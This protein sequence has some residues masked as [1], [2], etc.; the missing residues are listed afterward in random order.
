[1]CKNIT[2][3]YTKAD[4][5]D[6]RLTFHVRVKAQLQGH[7]FLKAMQWVIQCNDDRKTL[8]LSKSYC[9]TSILTVLFKDLDYGIW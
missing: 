9:Q 7:F 4:K 6:L 5:Y 1:M 8:F 2:K 3:K